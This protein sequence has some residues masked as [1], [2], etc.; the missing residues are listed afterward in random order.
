MERKCLAAHR[1]YQP[2]IELWLADVNSIVIYFSVNQYCQ[3]DSVYGKSRYLVQ[4]Q[5][6]ATVGKEVDHSTPFRIQAKLACII[7]RFRKN[8]KLPWGHIVRTAGV[9]RGAYFKVK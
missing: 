2:G 8:K 3:A 1:L 5:I 9:R 6:G 4:I 7:A